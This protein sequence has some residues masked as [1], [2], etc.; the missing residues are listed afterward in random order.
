VVMPDHCHFLLIVNYDV[1]PHFDILDWL[2]HF[3]RAIE[4]RWAAM[5]DDGRGHAPRP[6]WEE[7]FW[8]DLSFDSR[9]LAAIRRYIR[10]NPARAAWKAAHPDRFALIPRLRHEVLPAGVP[11]HGMGDPTLLTSPFLF[12]VRLTARMTAEEHGPAIDAA[13]ARARQGWVP[14]S[15]F[16]SPGEISLFRRLT[17]EP[18]ARMVK[19]VP[20]ALA[21]KYDPSVV[22]SRLLAEGRLFMLSGFPAAVARGATISRANC[23]RMNDFAAA[24][25]EKAGHCAESLVVS[26]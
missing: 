12:H 6:E 22:E 4:A 15:G 17:E 11:W 7:A 18:H 25:C 10:M 2:H 3:R 20:Y 1:D 16:I 23:N 8:L 21:P 14:V 26:R 13:V 24:L 5:A 19:V 9:Q